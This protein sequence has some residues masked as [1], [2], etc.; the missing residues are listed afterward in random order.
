MYLYL[1]CNQ[2]NNGGECMICNDYCNR[3]LENL[4]DMSSDVNL[5][6]AHESGI[7]SVPIGK[8]Y[9]AVGIKKIRNQS[10]YYAKK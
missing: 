2:K 3:I 5:V 8:P 9:V 1:G 10:R 7:K 4:N 6:L